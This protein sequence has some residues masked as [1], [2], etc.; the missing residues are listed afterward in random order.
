MEKI[1][2]LETLGNHTNLPNL[3]LNANIEQ[4]NILNVYKQENKSLKVMLQH[5]E[6]TLK[7][8]ENLI[9]QY[10][11]EIQSL[12]KTIKKQK[13]MIDSLNLE[14]SSLKNHRSSSEEKKKKKIASSFPHKKHMKEEFLH[15]PSS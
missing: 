13:K 3:S 7:T 15:I 14:I 10:V 12:K 8:R 4:M 2:S 1:K 5:Y 11:D 9:R 6:I